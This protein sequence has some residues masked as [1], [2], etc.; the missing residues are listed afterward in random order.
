MERAFPIF[1]PT[2]LRAGDIVARDSDGWFSK[3]IRWRTNAKWSHDAIVVE[4]DG[5]L[6]L[7]DSLWGK[8]S[9]L[10]PLWK[11]EAQCRAKEIRVLVMR[12][13]GA[14]AEQGR[15]AAAWWCENVKGRRYDWLAIIRLGIGVVAKWFNRDVGLKTNFY[16]TEGC[17]KSWAAAQNNPWAPNASPTPGTTTKRLKDGR[18]ILRDEALTNYGIQFR[19][20]A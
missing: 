15:A 2:E 5:G 9:A 7:G 20:A 11:W 13:E 4:R 8:R 17:A 18:L 10:T 6:Y 1:R 16:C 19:I 3:A 14:T 12:P